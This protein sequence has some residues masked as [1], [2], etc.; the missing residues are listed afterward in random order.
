MARADVSR[1]THAFPLFLTALPTRQKS[2]WIYLAV[3]KDDVD[4][5][6]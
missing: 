5:F 4:N 3:S 6:D 1:W 2:I